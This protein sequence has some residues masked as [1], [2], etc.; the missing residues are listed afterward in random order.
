MKTR[1]VAIAL[2]VSI[3]GTAL[4]LLTLWPVLRPLW[5][6]AANGGPA[7]DAVHL[8][9]HAQSVLAPLLI[10]EFIALALVAYVV[11]DLTVGRPLRRTED[12]VEQL[13]QL[14][15]ELPFESGGG[16]LLSR[17]QGSLR[18]LADA[19]RREQKLTESQL[20]ELRENNERLTRAQSELIRSEQLALL[21]RLAAGIAHEVGNPLM[22]ILG[23]LSLLKDKPNVTPDVREY[24][25][26]IESEV[27]RIDGIVRGLLDLGRAPRAVPVPLE[28]RSVAQSC[29]ELL[30]GGKE[31]VEVRIVNELPGELLAQADRALLSQVLLN[32][33]LNAAQAM[34]GKGTVTLNAETRNDRVLLHVDD[35]GPGLAPEVLQRLFEPFFT[36]KGAG[37]G[38]GLG[39]AVSRQLA[40]ALGGELSAVNR[41]RG[42]RFT[43]DLPAAQQR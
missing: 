6:A 13:E 4:T 43:L 32:L 41:E 28:L 14:R 24:V 30:K 18:R 1:I 8:L 5:R 23:Y 12:T 42:A 17:V 10:L 22:G 3:A 11:L 7:P 27:Q 39:L 25:V 38:T 29:A 40:H 33:I 34:G 19:L 36:T 37:K 26:R 16:P 15:L 9:H 2:L 35:E 21:G 20:N 31:F